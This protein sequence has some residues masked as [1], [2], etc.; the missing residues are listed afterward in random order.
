MI[1][2]RG[3]PDPAGDDVVEVLFI[4]PGFFCEPADGKGMLGVG[5]VDEKRFDRLAPMRCADGTKPFFLYREIFAHFFVHGS[6]KGVLRRP[7]KIVR[8]LRTTQM[9][10]VF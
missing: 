7:L 10:V 8:L 4:D 2:R 9:Q 6:S 5:P 3:V 1:V